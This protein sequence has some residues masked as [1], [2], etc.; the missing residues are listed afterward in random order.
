[1]QDGPLERPAGD[2]VGKYVFMDVIKRSLCKHTLENGSERWVAEYGTR[3]AFKVAECSVVRYLRKRTREYSFS[4]GDLAIY[5][6]RVEISH[7]PAGSG[8]TWGITSGLGTQ[9]R[10]WCSSASMKPEA[11]SST[12]QNLG[13][14]CILGR[15]SLKD[16]EFKASLG[17][18]ASLGLA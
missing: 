10:S 13:M 6:V 5:S 14:V 1:M 15:R 7:S 3:V 2:L 17:Y 12:T 11:P 18:A 16:Q 8:T 9:L 4:V